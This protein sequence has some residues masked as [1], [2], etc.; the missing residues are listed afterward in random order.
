MIHTVVSMEG[1]LFQ[2]TIRD[3]TRKYELLLASQDKT[4]KLSAGLQDDVI[5][6]N[7]TL[8]DI[9]EKVFAF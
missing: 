3:Q 4:N 9:V 6:F 2:E 5:S 8:T 7:R 1:F